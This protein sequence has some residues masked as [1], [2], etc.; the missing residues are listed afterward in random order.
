MTLDQALDPVFIFAA[1]VLILMARDIYEATRVALADL[2]EVQ[3]Q[4]GMGLIRFYDYL[5]V[6]VA[7]WVNKRSEK[8]REP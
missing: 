1:I 4:I 8:E 7:R 5:G 3:Y 2:R 6:V